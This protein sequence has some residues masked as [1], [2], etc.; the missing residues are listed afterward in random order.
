MTVLFII[1]CCFSSGTDLIMTVLFITHRCF[2]YLTTAGLDLL[3][4]IF[5]KGGVTATVTPNRIGS[6]NLVAIHAI[7]KFAVHGYCSNNGATGL[8]IAYDSKSFTKSFIAEVASLIV[9]E[10]AT[11]PSSDG[12]EL[13]VI[14]DIMYVTSSWPDCTL[15][16]KPRTVDI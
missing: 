13:P 11:S 10:A 15:A 2:L 12:A 1:H 4:K 5:D 8:V 9:S 14:R 3:P 16:N 6:V 7:A